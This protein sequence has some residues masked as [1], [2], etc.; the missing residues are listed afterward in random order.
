[1]NNLILVIIGSA[2]GGGVRYWLSNA[3]YRYFPI[4][5]PYGT[6]IVN[7]LGSLLLGIVI[8][9]LS[10]REIINTQIRFFLTLGFCGGFTTFST[11][12]LETFNLLRDSQYF[13]AMMNVLSNVFLCLL[14]IILA[15][16]FSKMI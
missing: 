3:V 14:G 2:L 15:Y 11:F 6:L 8:F 13:F 7:F 10:D 1:M 9:F 4:S 12:S 5:F 16:I